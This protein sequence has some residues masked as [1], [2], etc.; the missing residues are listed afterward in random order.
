MP[1][2]PQGL[3]GAVPRSS[4]PL[5]ILR[6]PTS[7]PRDS[8]RRIHTADRSCSAS[9]RIAPRARFAA[10][11]LPRQKLALDEQL[12]LPLGQV[13]AGRHREPFVVVRSF[14]TATGPGSQQSSDERSS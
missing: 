11:R 3:Q 8:P 1:G 5:K 14:S 7:I 10:A 2:N 4:P 12:R 6:G 9:L 13:V